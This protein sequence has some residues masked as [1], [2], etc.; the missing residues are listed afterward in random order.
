VLETLDLMGERGLRQAE[1]VRGV[2]EVET[3]GGL[4]E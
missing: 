4:Q 3:L 2:S 1:V